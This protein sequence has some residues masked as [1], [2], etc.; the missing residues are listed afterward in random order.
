MKTIR[1]I[2]E[3]IEQ[4]VFSESDNDLEI[5]VTIIYDENEALL[6]DAGYV[7]HALAVKKYH[8]MFS[9][10]A[11]QNSKNIRNMLVFIRLSPL[12]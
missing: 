11:D 7:P 8:S 9:A 5:N 6:I 2:N 10:K 4:F 3:T 12:N 1:K